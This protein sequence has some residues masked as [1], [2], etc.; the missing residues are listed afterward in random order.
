MQQINRLIIKAKKIAQGAD[1]CFAMGVVEYDCGTKRYIAKPQLWD[2]KAG[3][4]TAGM[5]MPDW[6]RREWETEEE[7][8][9]ALYGL[10]AE[11]RIP[12]A[13]SVLFLMDYELED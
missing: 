8:V 6:W 12:E 9:N 7:A 3:S 5:N 11:F 2:G 1:L 4:G 13:N 10:F